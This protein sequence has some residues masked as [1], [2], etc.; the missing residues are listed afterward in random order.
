MK[1]RYKISMV[2]G[3]IVVMAVLALA[4]LPWKP[5]AGHALESFLAT[6]G[7]RDVHFKLTE[8]T[9]R[10]AVFR[11]VSVGKNRALTA[12]HLVL[13]YS[14]P[15]NE[16]SADAAGLQFNKDDMKAHAAKASGHIKNGDGN[17]SLED[18]ALQAGSIT[19]PVIDGSGKLRSTSGTF[20]LSGGLKSK[21]DAYRADFSLDYPSAHPDNAQ[22]KLIYVSMPWKGG[23][24]TT[25]DVAVPLFGRQPIKLTLQIRQ[26]STDALLQAMTGQHVSAT[27]TVS[28]SLPLVIDRDGTVSF[29]AGILQADGAGNISM[30]ADAIPANN[31]QVGMVRD[32]LKNFH[33]KALSINIDSDKN[34]V[35]LLVA[36]EGNNPDMYDGRPVKLNVHLA[37]DVLGYI[38]QNVLFLTSPETLLKQDKK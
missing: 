8:A 24:L 2:I 5:L 7:L 12:D 9:P 36:L 1:T 33:Y 35:S 32:I 26:V 19:L 31:E 25:K 13:R 37:G 30:P 28:G 29:G 17:W 6:Q 15:G 20:L 16:I 38:R 21:D 14:P 4:F 23:T 11:D 34:G 27:G 22:L 18:T 3:A 10:G